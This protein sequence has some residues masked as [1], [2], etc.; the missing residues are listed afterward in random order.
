MKLE[1]HE[2]QSAL[3]KKLAGHVAERIETLR[4]KNDGDLND[5][6]TARLRGA[7]AEL[8]QLLELG[9]DLPPVEADD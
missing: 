8:K 9:E 3:W 4:R 6:Q 5:T 7:L 2:R 1:L